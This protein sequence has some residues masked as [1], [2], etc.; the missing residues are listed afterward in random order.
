VV[1]RLTYKDI[2]A[3]FSGDIST[4][5]SENLLRDPSITPKLDAHI[6]KAPHHGSSNFD[7]YFL[8]AI[9]PQLSVISSGDE[10]DQGH[11][12]AA[13]IGAIGKISRSTEPLLFS[14]EITASFVEEKKARRRDDIPRAEE[15]LGS[16]DVTKPE[17]A[18]SARIR[19]KRRL[20]GTINVR[21]DGHNLFAA[22]RVA[23]GY[24]WE[25]YGPIAP[26]R[27]SWG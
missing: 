23:S 10:P 22:R 26:S 11:P 16:L 25:S 8:K 15:E 14:R 18:V 17:A 24:W 5:G 20:H 9:R 21:T 7:K 4:K 19:F 6:F 12:R 13:F 2:S 1:I 3:L 27:G